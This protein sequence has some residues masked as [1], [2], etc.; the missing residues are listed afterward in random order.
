MPTL[1]PA[2]VPLLHHADLIPG[3]RR[4]CRRDDRTR[5]ASF[6]QL[7]L[8]AGMVVH[9]AHPRIPSGEHRLV[10]AD[11]RDLAA[12]FVDGTVVGTVDQDGPEIPVQGS[13]AVI[14]LDV[15]VESLGRVGPQVTLYCPAPLLRAGVN[16]VT[17]L[18]LER[19]GGVL[20]LRDRPEL[21]PAE[22]YIE[23]FT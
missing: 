23:E 6:E 16:T 15:V 18:E 22:E 5:P 1:A 8:D 3:L 17:A 10:L 7:G 12:V 4:A 13:G 2:R 21:G 11:V 19:L 20:A 14:R 9:T